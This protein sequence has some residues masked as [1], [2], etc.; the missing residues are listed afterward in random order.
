MKKLTFICIIMSR[1][2]TVTTKCGTIAVLLKNPSSSSIS[3]FI[4]F[5]LFCLYF[6]SS[7]ASSQAHNWAQLSAVTHCHSF[8]SSLHHS[9]C[10]SADLGIHLSIHLSAPFSLTSGNDEERQRGE[11]KKERR[12]EREERRGGEEEER[13]TGEILGGMT[14]RRLRHRE[15]DNKQ[16]K[17]RLSKCCW[18]SRKLLGNRHKHTVVRVSNAVRDNKGLPVR[19]KV[20]PKFTVYSQC[21]F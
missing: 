15:G 6:S 18:W 9:F 2:I 16:K 12:A 14:E 11:E 8:I 21:C 7:S 19:I 3:S 1:I 20:R 10:P 4:P 17:K 13:E 5:F